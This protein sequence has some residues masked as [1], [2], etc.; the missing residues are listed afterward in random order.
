L[1][2]NVA[3]KNGPGSASQQGPFFRLRHHRPNINC[4]TYLGCTRY[5]QSNPQGFKM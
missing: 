2:P 3:K 1:K 5:N 4:S